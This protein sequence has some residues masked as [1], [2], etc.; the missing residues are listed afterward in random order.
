MKKSINLDISLTF[1]IGLILSFGTYATVSDLEEAKTGHL[2]KYSVNNRIASIKDN[3]SKH[4]QIVNSLDSLF[5][6]SEHVSRYEFKLY[7]NNILKHNSEVQALS[8]NP[9]ITKSQREL[10][11]NNA[12]KD[13]LNN[14]KIRGFNS[15]GEIVEDLKKK[16]FTAVY[17]IEPYQQNKDA[18]GFDISSNKLRNES[19]KKAI[20]SGKA[21][22]TQRIS[23]IQKKEKTFGY[24]LLKPLFKKGEVVDTDLKRQKFFIG[25]VVGV[26]RFDKLIPESINNLEP[27]GIDILLSDVTNPTKKQFLHFHSSRMRETP[28]KQYDVDEENIENKLF[29]NKRV[30]ILGREWL[31]RFTPSPEFI[32]KNRSWNSLIYLIIGLTTTFILMMYISIKDKNTKRLKKNYLKIVSQKEKIYEQ[33]CLI[34]HQAKHAQM[35]ELLAMIAHQWRQPLSS[36]SATVISLQMQQELDMYDKKSYGEQ[37]DNIAGYTQ[38]LSDTINDFR[39]FLNEDKEKVYT[40]L[41]SIVDGSL[42][43]IKPMLK[44]LNIELKTDYRCSDKILTYPN[45]LKQVVLNIIKNSQDIIKEKS[46][47]NAVIKINTYK[48]GTKYYLEIIDNAG[49]I[50]EDIKEKIFDPYFTTKKDLN[51]TGLGL[52]MSKKII[53]ERCN[54]KLYAKNINDGACFTIELS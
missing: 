15:D 42:E 38:H 16:N 2:F 26:F 35:G 5:L 50:P 43:I 27:S 45:E 32:D 10:Y 40:D 22:I 20:K 47:K 30:D 4:I 51:G 36:I 6:S 34:T 44:N 8:W 39:E 23:L 31:F 19:I 3:I 9:L 7:T 53:E 28:V 21:T 41:S 29:I 52:Y 54:G 14:F 18:L 11:I 13:G 37:L 12:R 25:L 1:I 49:G 46:L 24:L 48:T 17:Y 33:N